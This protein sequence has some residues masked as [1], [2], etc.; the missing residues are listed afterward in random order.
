MKLSEG[1]E[2]EEEG[3]GSAEAPGDGA[4]EED[5]A[6]GIEQGEDKADWLKVI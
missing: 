5:E 1:Y 2:G 6:E 4:P 3:L